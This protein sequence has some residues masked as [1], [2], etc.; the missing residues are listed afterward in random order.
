MTEVSTP[1]VITPQILTSQVST[2]IPLRVLVYNV[3]EPVPEPIRYYGQKERAERLQSVIQDLDRQYQIDVLIL[4][5]VIAPVAQKV[6]LPALHDIGFVYKT[7]KLTDTFTVT[8]GILIFS[9]HPITMEDQTLFGDKCTGIDC[10]AAKGAVYARIKKQDFYFNILGVHM[11]AWPNL[12]AQVIRDAQ[13]EQMQK[14]ITSLAIPPNEPFLM[15]GDLNT[16]LFLNNDQ[17]R[18]L[19]YT[20]KMDIPEI[21]PES[22]PFTVDPKVNKLVGADDPAEYYN[23]QWP[24]GCIEEYHT[25]L[26]CPCCPQEW[27]DYVLHSKNHLKPES[28]N[29]KAIPVK[30]A[31]FR[32]KITM[33]QEIEAQDLSDH[34]PVLGDFVFSIDQI[35]PEKNTDVVAK[36]PTPIS[37]NTSHVTLV[38]CIIA[39]VLVILLVLII[40]FILWT[41]KKFAPQSSHT[42]MS[43]SG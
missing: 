31:P 42:K 24:D 20:L 29:M 39:L 37:C 38:S 34:F 32:M 23:E 9:K 18:H 3:M 43:L 10:F 30:V 26:Q 17:L 40:W 8:G 19:M 2:Q 16:D 14:F 22:Y 36:D 1:K 27:L 6:I 21:H 28:C 7:S 25:T 12:T 5:E 15:G 11:Q 13:M 33:T 35:N 4:N 41:R